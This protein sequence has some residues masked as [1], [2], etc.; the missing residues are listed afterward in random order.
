MTSTV[1]NVSLQC[2]T[3]RGPFSVA[4]Y[5]D[6]CPNSARQLSRL[7][8]SGF[9]SQGLSFWRVNKWVAQFGEDETGESRL[10]RGKIDP[11]KSVRWNSR[12]D[13]HP[14]CGV[15][16]RGSCKG[17]PLLKSHPWRRGTLAL[18]G[19][20]NILVVRRDSSAMGTNAHDC[21]VGMVEG[22]GMATVFDGLYS[23]YGNQ[24]DTKTGPGH[25]HVFR[26][27]SSALR[28]QW[29]RLDQLY[30]C[31]MVARWPD[32]DRTFP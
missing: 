2:S 17:K 9:L 20:L 11:F 6:A 22:D 29:P 13:V 16:R 8:Q 30:N 31:T 23:G 12:R 28:Q 4:L 25:R 7:V 32:N 19:G 24:L 1:S 21:P 5:P 18:I 3:S 14:H 27:E 15:A 10:K 26:Q